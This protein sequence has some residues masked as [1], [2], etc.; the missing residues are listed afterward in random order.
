MSRPGQEVALDGKWA[1]YM[2]ETQAG[3]F[4]TGTT[5]DVSSRYRAHESGSGARAVRLAGGPRR[6]VWR[7]EGLEKADAFRLE[8]AIK[9]LSRRGK[10]RLIACGLA[11]VGLAPDGRTAKDGP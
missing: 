1:V 7:Q 11:A 4:Y 10:E 3:S 2:I 8:R 9:R 6:I 5:T